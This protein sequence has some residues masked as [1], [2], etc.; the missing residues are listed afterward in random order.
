[1]YDGSRG[2]KDSESDAEETDNCSKA[3]VGWIPTLLLSCCKSMYE[4]W[5]LELLTATKRTTYGGPRDW[6]NDN[7]DV[8]WKSGYTRKAILEQ[9]P[10]SSLAC[11]YVAGGFWTAHVGVFDG[12]L[13][14]VWFSDVSWKVY[15]VWVYMISLQYRVWGS[16]PSAEQSQ[17]ARDL[18]RE[19]ELYLI[20]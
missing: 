3:P 11:P 2:C 15:F 19:D 6:G 20:L 8:E 16:L 7:M 4:S 17:L 9:P 13:G 5:T 1:M 18:R 14:T 12:F 10:I